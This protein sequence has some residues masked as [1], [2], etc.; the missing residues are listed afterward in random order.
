MKQRKWSRGDTIT[1][2]IGVDGACRARRGVFVDGLF[3]GRPVGIVVVGNM[4]YNLVTRLVMG[5]RIKLAVQSE[6]YREWL[7]EELLGKDRVEWF[8]KVVADEPGKAPLLLA[9]EVAS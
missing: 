2:C 3:R 9:E 8:D 5:C 7:R 4:S 1:T 6:E